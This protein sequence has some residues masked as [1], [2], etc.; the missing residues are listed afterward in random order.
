MLLSSRGSSPPTPPRLLKTPVRTSFNNEQY[1]RFREVDTWS[2][3]YGISDANTRL[4]GVEVLTLGTF[5]YQ[6]PLC[7]G[8]LICVMCGPGA[9]TM[10]VV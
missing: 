2:K 7:A 9:S 1:T 4:L 8:L 6:V 3:Q 5:G 10:F